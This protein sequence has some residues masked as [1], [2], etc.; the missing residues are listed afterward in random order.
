MLRKG[1]LGKLNNCLNRLNVYSTIFYD[2]HCLSSQ[3]TKDELMKCSTKIVTALQ[4]DCKPQETIM[5]GTTLQNMLSAYE[6]VCKCR[7]ITQIC[8]CNILQYFTAVK[9]LISR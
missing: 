6:G 8:P 9:M 4:K 5:V 3:A 7:A 2:K 1:M